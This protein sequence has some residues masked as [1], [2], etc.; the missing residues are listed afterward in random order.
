MRWRCQK[1]LARPKGVEP[2]TDRSEL[3]AKIRKISGKSPEICDN[4]RTMKTNIKSFSEML[5]DDMKAARMTKEKLAGKAGLSVDT[6][7]KALHGNGISH[8][9]RALIASAL[10]FDADHYENSG[11]N[12]DSESEE[13]GGRHRPVDYHPKTELGK[14]LW[15]LRLEHVKSG[16]RLLTWNEIEE[17]KALARG[18]SE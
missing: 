15:K 18:D 3:S 13:T 10:G 5:L 6:I 7:R 2:P 4:G 8:G 1:D 11:S 16:A 17:E 14:R 9:S 12:P